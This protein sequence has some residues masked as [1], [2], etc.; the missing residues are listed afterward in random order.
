VK[1]GMRNEANL[2]RTDRERH[3]RP[4]PHVRPRRGQACETKPI[5]P[6]RQGGQIPCGKRVMVNWT[7]EGPRRNKA[8]FRKDSNGPRPARVSASAVGPVVQTKPIPGGAGGTRPAGACT[9]KPNLPRLTV[10]NKANFRQAGWL[11][12]IER[13]KQSQFGVA[14]QGRPSPRPEALTMPPV[15]GTNVRNKANSAGGTGRA[16]SWWKRSY[17]ELNMQKTSAKQSQFPHGPPWVTAGK[18]AAG[19]DRCAKRSQFASATTFCGDW[20][21]ASRPPALGMVEHGYQ[22]RSPSWAGPSPKPLALRLPPGTDA[23]SPFC[24]WRNSPREI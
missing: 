1:C 24:L 14:G 8:N 3:R 11:E 13:A 21:A 17:G 2:P 7:S 22:T 19:G 23:Q 5:P 15:R 12:P 10:R 16:S 18:A 9:N 4:G 6:E 20:V